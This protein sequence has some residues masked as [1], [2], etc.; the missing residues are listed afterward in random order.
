MKKL[1]LTSALLFS[2]NANALKCTIGQNKAIYNVEHAITKDQKR[3]GLMFRKSMP[4]NHGMLFSWETPD[5]HAMWMK[6]TFI[7]LDMLFINDNKV[8]GII[9][10][11]PPHSLKARY[12]ESPVNQI[13]EINA[14][15]AQK[16]SIAI[17]D[18]ISCE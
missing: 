7:P 6:N 12:I 5:N 9:A 15:Q 14:G 11:I 18:T 16:N 3:K 1:L 17:G 4:E 10:D 2:F 13:L 8:M